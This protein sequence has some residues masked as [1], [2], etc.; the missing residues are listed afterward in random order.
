RG[1]DVYGSGTAR[2]GAC[3]VRELRCG[4]E[5]LNRNIGEPR[6]GLLIRFIRDGIAG[7]ALAVVHPIFAERAVAVEDEQGS[8]SI[9]LRQHALHHIWG[10]RF[11]P[12]RSTS[13]SI[14]R[15]GN[16]SVSWPRHDS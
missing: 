6:G 7:D 16:N 2:D 13:G 5:L 8:V 10:P 1:I 3:R 14:S 12:R 4:A 9:G 11:R 15:H